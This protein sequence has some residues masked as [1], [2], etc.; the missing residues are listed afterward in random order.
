MSDERLPIPSSFRWN[1]FNDLIGEDTEGGDFWLNLCDWSPELDV[2]LAAAREH[3]TDVTSVR[4]HAIPRREL[5]DP[6]KLFA[7]YKEVPLKLTYTVAKGESF[8]S[9]ELLSSSSV[10]ATTYPGHP[11]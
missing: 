10:N 2:A 5:L 6:G 1:L 3:A 7:D 8:D 11:R 4:V 9:G